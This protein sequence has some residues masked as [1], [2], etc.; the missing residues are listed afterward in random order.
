LLQSRF[1]INS[2]SFSVSNYPQVKSH[3]VLNTLIG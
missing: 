1:H 2:N 3:E